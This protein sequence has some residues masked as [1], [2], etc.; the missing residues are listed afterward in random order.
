MKSNFLIDYSACILFRVLGAVFRALPVEWTLFAGRRLGDWFYYFDLKHKA[1]CYA[2]IK[3]ALGE[4]LSPC[5]VARVTKEFY[6]SFGQSLIEI[7]LIPRVDQRYMRRYIEIEGLENIYNGLK[8][9]KGVVLLAVHSGSW[10]LANIIC[11]NC[12]F[13]FYLFVK[14]QGFPVLNELLNKYRRQKGCKIITKEGGLKQLIEALKNNAAVGITLDQGGK[15]GELVDF[16][17]KAA[18]MS[19]GGIKLA[20]KYGSV[21]LPVY[22]L[23]NRGPRV[24]VLVGEEFALG[25]SGDLERDISGSLIKATRHFEALIRAYPKEYLWTYKIWKYADQREILIL[26]DGKTGHLRQSE[27]ACRIIKERLEKRGLRVKVNVAEVKFR[28]RFA[29]AVLS[30]SGLLAGKYCCQGCLGSLRNALDAA[31]FGTLWRGRPDIVLSSGS[32]LAAVNFMISRQNLSRSVAVMRP[33]VLSVNKFDLVIMPRH[34]SPPRK[35]NVVATQAALNLVNEAYLQEQAAKLLRSSF[36]RFPPSGDSIGLLLGGDSKGFHLDPAAVAGV[37]RQIKAVSER[38]G[39]AILVTTSR[40]TG[41]AVE[42]L[43]RREFKDHARCALMIIANEENCPEAIG[44]ILGL[45]KVIV[46]SPESISMISEAANSGKPVLVF[47]SGKLDR[48][49]KLFLDH[50]AGGGHIILSAVDSLGQKIEGL[51]RAKPAVNLLKDNEAVG[52][53]VDKI[54]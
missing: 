25:R 3:H 10:E 36:P 6:R 1:R 49:H 21:M 44:G 32:A 48:R 37:I 20:L 16:F 38:T 53:A 18:S 54:L 52:E 12:G 51:W 34:D 40:R 46:V 11:A 19:T 5:E 24:K 45:S 50:L 35:K 15:S 28:H 14:D 26:S 2:N 47:G 43:V 23:R 42:E 27:A 4:E 13:P 31:T 41:K 30:L 9:G 33:S 29:G 8:K 39:A 7:L 22:F 17:G